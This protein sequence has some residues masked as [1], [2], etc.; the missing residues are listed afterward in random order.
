MPDLFRNSPDATA[1]ETS[2]DAR[3]PVWIKEPLQ[4]DGA[5]ISEPASFEWPEMK[6]EALG[7][8]TNQLQQVVSC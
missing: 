1:R 5:L 7:E 3:T 2:G 4:K 6:P 8:V